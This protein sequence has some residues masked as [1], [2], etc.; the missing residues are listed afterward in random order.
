VSTAVL[1][2]P[3]AVKGEAQP[4]RVRLKKALAAYEGGIAALEEYGAK[5][6]RAQVDEEKALGNDSESESEVANRISSA[7]NLKRVY[8][9]RT[10]AKQKALTGQ[11][12]ELKLAIGAAIS[13]LRGDLDRERENRLLV[14]KPR[15]LKAGNF[16]QEVLAR[17]E[18]LYV[19]EYCA[20]IHALRLLEIQFGPGQF[21]EPLSAL[22]YAKLT[23]ENFE[24]LALEK[25]RE[26]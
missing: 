26:I 2:R 5:V 12:A 24:T 22:N 6:A 23:L 15:I 13:E 11:F 9:S 21:D 25:Q 1:E 8:E 7:Q 17:R 18:F 19:M 3:A 10:A 20:A 14:L 16:A 4:S